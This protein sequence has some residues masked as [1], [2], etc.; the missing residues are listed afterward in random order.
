MVGS[1]RDDQATGQQKAHR[2]RSQAFFGGYAPFG[3][4]KPLPRSTSDKGH[5]GGWAEHGNRRHKSANPARGLEPNQTDDQATGP[6]RR[7]RDG[8]DAGE[9][10]IGEPMI[11]RHRLPMHVGQHSIGAAEGEQ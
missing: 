8:I 4:P 1:A 7:L 6:R 10:L 9:L 2:Y 11:D 5:Y 3:I